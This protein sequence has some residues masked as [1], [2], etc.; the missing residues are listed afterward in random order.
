M[1]KMEYFDILMELLHISQNNQNV[2]DLRDFIINYPH[3][4]S[5]EPFVGWSLQERLLKRLS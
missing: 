5:D 2:E 3:N 4:C 1:G